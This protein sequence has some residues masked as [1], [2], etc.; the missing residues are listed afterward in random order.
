MAIR[1]Y[2]VTVE[3][4]KG[5]IKLHRT[6]RVG[7]TSSKRARKKALRKIPGRTGKVIVIKELKPKRDLFSFG[8][9]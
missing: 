5:P 7:A 3:W 2:K 4:W 1:Y 6:F 8:G 9:R